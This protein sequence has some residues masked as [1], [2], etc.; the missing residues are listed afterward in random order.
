MRS[1]PLN[2]LLSAAATI[3]LFA[4]GG[5]EKKTIEVAPNTLGMVTLELSAND[6]S[7]LITGLDGSRLKVGELS[8]V[9]GHVTIPEDGREGFGR[10]MTVQVGAEKA[11]HIS[12]GHDPLRLPPP[13]G[14]QV[15]A[16]LSDREVVSALQ[17]Y[18]VGF[19]EPTAAERERSYYYN[20]VHSAPS[21]CNPTACVETGSG[22]EN[23]CCG[24]GTYSARACNDCTF[25]CNGTPTNCG[26][27]GTYGCAPCWTD[28]WSANC[29]VLSD[30]TWVVDTCL[31]DGSFCNSDSDCCAN[32]CIYYNSW[33]CSSD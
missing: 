1:T 26:S 21:S 23:I 4:C 14:A 11:E 33:Y 3:V 24:A 16:F 29:N 18:G 8:L 13:A 28:T 19:A 17:Q 2:T 12:L 10:H 31:A 20:C 15:K 32:R 5:P 25:G 27:A 6:N 7:L 9:T 22:Y 30:G